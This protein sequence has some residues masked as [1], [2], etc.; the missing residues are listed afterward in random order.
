[1]VYVKFRTLDCDFIE[2]ES[3]E[4]L[5]N[6]ENYN[7]ITWLQIDDTYFTK[8]F[9][10]PKNLTDLYISDCK[11]VGTINPLPLNIRYV[12]IKDCYTSLLDNLFSNN[13]YNNIETLNLSHNRLTKIPKNLPQNIISIK[14]FR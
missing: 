10:L 11:N 7:D 1:M 9:N 6:F 5:L 12:E 3:L 13:K 4:E 14:M 2:T 8:K